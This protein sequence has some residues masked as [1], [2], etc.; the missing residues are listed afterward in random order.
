[1]LP[2]PGDAELGTCR[3]ETGPWSKMPPQPHSFED[4]GGESCL[5]HSHTH[6]PC[7]SDWGLQAK[8][9]CI[10]NETKVSDKAFCLSFINYISWPCGRSLCILTMCSFIL[11]SVFIWLNLAAVFGMESFSIWLWNAPHRPACL[12][13]WLPAGDA[14]L[15]LWRLAGGSGSLGWDL[16]ACGL[17]LLLVSPSVR[18][19]CLM[20]QPLSH[21]HCDGQW[22]CEIRS[23]HLIPQPPGH[24]HCDGW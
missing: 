20:P 14:V 22:K 3:S 21:P 8:K 10:F 11:N 13:I 5:I 16:E 23:S 18:N 19:S 6:L 1:M 15:E 24:L 12:N 4:Y 17:P 9:Y 2:I 7:V